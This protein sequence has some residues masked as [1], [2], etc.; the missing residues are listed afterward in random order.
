VDIEQ[1]A[2]PPVDGRDVSAA[3]VSDPPNRKAK[4][5]AAPEPA[6]ERIDNLSRLDVL[7]AVTDASRSNETSELNDGLGRTW[8]VSPDIVDNRSVIL[9]RAVKARAVAVQTIPTSAFAVSHQPAHD[10]I[11]AIC[12]QLP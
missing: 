10:A 7:Q 3:P 2:P 8:H 6:P 11:D 5:Q 1:D 9:L 4:A 12:A